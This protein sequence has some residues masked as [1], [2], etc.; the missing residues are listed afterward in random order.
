VRVL[1]GLLSAASIARPHNCLIA[2]ASVATGA[3]LARGSL[4]GRAVA[5][6]V[7]AFLVC[8]GAYALNDYY[9]V[10]ADRLNRPS[11]PLVTGSVGT[12]FVLGLTVVCWAGA[13]VAAVFGGKQS[14]AFGV[15][16]VAL[17]WLYSWRLKGLGLAGHVVVSAVASSGFLLG[18][19]SGGRASAGIMPGLVAL[20][21]HLGREFAK[22]VADLAGDRA[23]GVRTLA[24]R[25]GGRRVLML[26][27]V[28]IGSLAVVSV[29][30]FTVLGYGLGYMLPVALVGYPLLG[31][32]VY[33]I[34]AACGDERKVEGAGRA[35]AGLL[36]A[37]MPVGLVAFLMGGM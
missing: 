25:I 23:A 5:A 27:L 7:M 32:C 29:L 34:I 20:A 2:A 36:K 30:P 16:W 1:P 8:A 21:L 37:V 10:A 31:T 26:S 22:G 9:D 15:V 18:A 35:V 3:F 19:A 6:S 17:L 4:G 33:F 12:G 14:A 28:C 13:G 24:V 11:R